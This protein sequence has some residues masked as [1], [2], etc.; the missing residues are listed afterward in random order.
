MNPM[1]QPRAR[2][3]SDV[4]EQALKRDTAE[5]LSYVAEACAGN[6]ELQREVER[7]L[8]VHHETI[9]SALQKVRRLETDTVGPYRLLRK[10][11]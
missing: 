4:Y 1:D 7:L 6:Q 9:P 3:A 8:F 11:I 5:R 10:S 2:S